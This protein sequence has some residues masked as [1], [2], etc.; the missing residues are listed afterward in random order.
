MLDLMR[1]HA[2]SWMIKILLGAIALAFALSWGVSQYGQDPRPPAVKINGEAIA[3]SRV[4]EVYA[5][6]VEEA[7]QQLGAQFDRVAPLLNLRQRSLETL[8][9]QVLLSQAANQMGV[10]VSDLEVQQRLASVPVF[11]RDGRFDVELYRR[12][13]SRSRLTPEQ[14]E[15]GQRQ[16]LRMAKLSAL[17]AGTAQV[18][19][20]ELEQA[21]AQSLAKVQ[22]VYLLFKPEAYRK[23]VKA[24]DQEIE[25][26]YQA[27]KAQYLEPA[28]LRLDYIVFPLAEQRDQAK[29]SEDEVREAY[30]ADRQRYSQPESVAARHILFKLPEKPTPA[31]VKAAKEKAEKVLALAKRPKADFAKLAKRYSQGPTKDRGGDLG[32]FARGQM[33]G[34]FEELAFS[35]PVGG[36]G[37]A[38]TRFGWHVVKVYEHNQASV[39]PL[40]KVKEDIR[41]RLSERR[42]RE[43]AQAAAERAFDKL[44][45][46]G[47]LA[48]LAKQMNKPVARSPRVSRGQ[49]MEGLPGLQGLFA[50]AQDLKPGQTVP[51]LAFEGGSI[52]AVISERTEE[53][54]K[55]LA[56]VREQV[57]QAAAE[58]LAQD[59][60][61]AEAAKLLKDLA[62]TKNPAAELARLPHAARTG[63][64][65]REGRVEGLAGSSSLVQ[66]L[67]LQPLNKP[68]LPA[69]LSVGEGFAAAVLAGRRE[70]PAKEME[71]KRAEFKEQL[72]AAQRR[73]VLQSFLEDLRARAQVLVPVQGGA[74][75]G[76]IPGCDSPGSIE[77]VPL[78][79]PRAQAQARAQR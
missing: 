5:N 57:R 71:A 8:V 7:K 16:E 17:V 45:L 26:Y 25:K 67:L 73:Q 63:W 68:V 54:A 27:H 74:S 55:P 40:D 69:P 1:K 13:L 43:L 48:D 56:Q 46:S 77:W 66:T 22:G 50:A 31:E 58:R 47:K 36:L 70:A 41:A 53:K 61:R 75:K 11:Q 76:L 51:A 38:Q 18:T 39:T 2:G 6:L 10:Q 14:F 78:D 37:L 21:L 64:L 79:S 15:A 9:N 34:P 30:E 35:L 12:I 72:L 28:S 60:A 29:V 4:S 23:D 52:L 59:K 33:V 44:A 62:A 24:T 19:P 42:A 3:E 32:R 49:K 20:L 65:G